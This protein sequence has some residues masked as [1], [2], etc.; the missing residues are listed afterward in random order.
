MAVALL[1]P[2]LLGAAPVGSGETISL[3]GNEPG[4]RLDV[5]LTQVTDPASPTGP[6]PEPNGPDPAAV[7]FA[8]NG[9]LAD[10]VGHWSLP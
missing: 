4:Q 8:L 2:V 1:V 5:T 6:D 3:A 9:G 7:Q 10:D